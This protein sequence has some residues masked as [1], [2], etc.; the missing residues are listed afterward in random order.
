M[1]ALDCLYQFLYISSPT[2]SIETLE[3]K[4]TWV[5]VEASNVE[6]L[7]SSD[8]GWST[9]DKALISDEFVS[10]QK[11]VFGLGLVRRHPR[12]RTLEVNGRSRC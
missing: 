7:F 9:L 12:G 5:D 4:I 1:A 10:L 6:T 8:G 3:I 11:V 2:S